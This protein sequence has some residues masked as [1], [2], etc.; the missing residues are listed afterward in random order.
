MSKLVA[1]SYSR[2]NAYEQ[3][4][5]KFHAISVAKTIKEEETSMMSYGTELHK[6][7][8]DFFKDG[9]KLPL[10]M[11]QY[12]KLLTQIKAAPGTFI[13]EQQLAINDKYEA[14]GWFD[15]DVYCR[16]ISDLT[17][18]NDKVAVMIDHKTG[19]ISSDFMQLKLAAAVMFLLVPELEKIVM[20]YLWTKTKEITRQTMTRD[21]MPGVWNDLL[22]RIQRYQDAHVSQDWPARP[23]YLCRYCP[24]KACQYHEKKS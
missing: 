7:F 16:I 6:A 17:I 14:T 20:C 13:T 21:E 5:K 24:I 23:S 3:C 22:P 15:K 11:Q 2:L 8:A 9:K 12:T 18:L 1:F 19:K 4:P 10:H